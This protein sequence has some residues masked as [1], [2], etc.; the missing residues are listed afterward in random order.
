LAVQLPRPI[1]TGTK[2]PAL[3]T[4][5]TAFLDPQIT[6]QQGTIAIQ[7]ASITNLTS[8]VAQRDA[9]IATLQAQIAGIPATVAAALA[10]VQA[11]LDVANGLIINLGLEIDSLS[12]SIWSFGPKEAFLASLTNTLQLAAGAGI[13]LPVVETP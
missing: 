6:T 1:P 12:D 10:P 4:E 5:I 11:E 7:G 13:L 8:D 3:L 2:A 9:T